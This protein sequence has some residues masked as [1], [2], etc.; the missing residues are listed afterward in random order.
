[1]DCPYS[2]EA[3]RRYVKELG[4]GGK[5]RFANYWENMRWEIR[6]SSH[7]VGKLIKI[8]E[9][10]EGAHLFKVQLMD[11]PEWCPEVLEFEPHTKL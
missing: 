7:V 4:E 10:S 9:S 2:A 1:V 5:Q 6:E 8:L 3:L 11:L